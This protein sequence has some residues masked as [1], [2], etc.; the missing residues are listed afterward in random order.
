MYD[1]IML[2]YENWIYKHENKKNDPLKTRIE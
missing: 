2:Q 1:S